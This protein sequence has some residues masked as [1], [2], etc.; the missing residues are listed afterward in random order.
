MLSVIIPT[1]WKYEPFTDFLK[2]LV[3]V[4]VIDE[5][6]VV[7]NNISSTPANIVLAHPKIKLLNCDQNILVNPAWNLGVKVSRN[8][9][10]C[11]V[12][13]DIVVDLK[14]FYKLDKFLTENKDTVGVAGL[15]EGRTE[16]GYNQPPFVNGNIDI[17]K[18]SGE[19][20]YGFG[21]LF[22]LRKENWMEI[23]NV[24]RV[25]FGDNWV[26]DSQLFLQ[27]KEN[28]YI[29]NILFYHAGAVT[30]STAF[31]DSNEFYE[32]EKIHYEEIMQ[33]IKQPTFVP[34]VNNQAAA[35]LEQEY[36]RACSTPTDIHLHLPTLRALADQCSH[37]TEMGVRDG[38]STRAIISSSAR[39]IR[40]YDLY[41]DQY[42]N[43]LAAVAAEAGK[44]IRYQAAD[45][46]QIDIEP[47]DLLFIDTDHTYE[48]LTAELAKHSDKARK[49]LAFH[50]TH[51]PW[52]IQLMPV[53][54]E[55][56]AIHPEW[57]V[58]SHTRNCHGF[59]VLERVF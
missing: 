52:G 23:P 22:F 26:F 24:L 39:T 32:K 40:S 42:V 31:E 45:V 4:D 51:E 19:N 14:V 49:Y 57:K 13:D 27:R 16:P 46:L 37:V 11:I 48:Q 30:T 53:I 38:Q 15:I 18:W 28:Y 6:I 47:T 10:I 21:T 44:D 12:N 9:N 1:M 43:Y 8:D 20:M 17:V 5:I 3:N 29:S 34:A 41:L 50:D 54:L 55:F 58:K 2:D 56:L 7:N 36:L 33:N 35:F 59:T 25:Y